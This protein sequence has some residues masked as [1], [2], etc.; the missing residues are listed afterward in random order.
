[1]KSLQIIWDTIIRTHTLGFFPGDIIYHEFTEEDG[2]S[3]LRNKLKTHNNLELTFPIHQHNNIANEVFAKLQFFMKHDLIET[4]HL[5]WKLKSNLSELF[6]KLPVEGHFYDLLL[7]SILDMLKAYHTQNTFINI[8]GTNIKTPPINTQILKDIGN[9]VI[10][11]FQI[12]DNYRKDLLWILTK[13]FDNESPKVIVYTPLCDTFMITDEDNISSYIPDTYFIVIPFS[14][15]AR[16]QDILDT[17]AHTRDN[18]IHDIKS[19]L[20]LWDSNTLTIH[21]NTKGELNMISSFTSNDLCNYEYFQSI[22]NWYGWL[23]INQHHHKKVQIK[24]EKRF[25]YT[26]WKKTKIS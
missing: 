5:S 2:F 26:D 15:S 11:E 12:K 24:W 8:Q 9:D 22:I 21:K 6:R 16:S 18:L 17:E 13:V 10:Y 14:W 7:D 1:M 4:F 20:D 3:Q 23:M 19:T 25:K